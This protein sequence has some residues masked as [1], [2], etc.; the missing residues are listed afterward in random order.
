MVVANDVALLKFILL[1]VAPNNVLTARDRE[2]LQGHQV[3]SRKRDSR[4]DVM[5]TL[6]HAT[7]R[8]N[9]RPRRGIKPRHE[10][11]RM[12]RGGRVMPFEP[13]SGRSR[14]AV[15]TSSHANGRSRH[16]SH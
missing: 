10:R 8:E 5:V 2:M 16:A 3:T 1:G 13:Y 9:E 14:D 4:I 7:P 15:G 11:L 12:S 6:S